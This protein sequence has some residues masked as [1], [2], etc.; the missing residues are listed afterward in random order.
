MMNED[1]YKRRLGR[2]MTEMKLKG[3]AFAL[4][5][6]AILL[7]PAMA[8]MAVSPSSGDYNITRQGGTI[9]MV[10]SNINP[11]E[12]EFKIAPVGNYEGN[13]FISKITPGDTLTVKPNDFKVFYVQ[14]V[15]DETVEYGK[16]YKIIMS[17]RNLG[18]VGSQ[19]GIGAAVGEQVIFGFNV[20]F[21]NRGTTVSFGG[22]D[23][24]ATRQLQN[25]MNRK[26]NYLP[27]ILAIILVLLLTAGLIYFLMWRRKK[28]QEEEEEIV[29]S[30]GK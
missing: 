1:K 17:A 13:K 20:I 24:G 3:V 19:Q 23:E 9:Q 11:V 15:P 8:A 10:L 14:I 22:F 5:S 21:E 25:E 6:L 26:P 16:P 18:A 30:K 4:L 27:L 29:V 28:A 2:G 7:A 12:A